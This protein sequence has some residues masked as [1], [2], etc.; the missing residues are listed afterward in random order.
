M[1]GN[2]PVVKCDSDRHFANVDGKES[3]SKSCG[4]GKVLM[5]LDKGKTVIAVADCHNNQ[6]IID[7][8][9]G[10]G[11]K[12]L[13]ICL[14]VKG[15]VQLSCLMPHNAMPA[16]VEA[17]NIHLLKELANAGCGVNDHGETGTALHVAARE[18]LEKA[19]D[20]LFELGADQQ[21]ALHW[22]ARNGKA[23]AVA[24][25][26]RLKADIEEEPAPLFFAAQNGHGEACK[27]LLK[28]KA[29]PNT[30]NA[31]GETPL[32]CAAKF[33]NHADVV[34]HLIRHHAEI[35]AISNDGETPLMEAG[36]VL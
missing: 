18:G 31:E 8:P 24:E 12:F 34:R 25:L 5:T 19:V 29:K 35:N 26:I 30:T 36:D 28:A 23:N 9:N 22:A 27:E 1:R 2:K 4:I 14:P 7:Q 17:R 6:P 11:T 3:D 10:Q 21:T 33:N 16:A 13:H 15:V 20:I 32:H